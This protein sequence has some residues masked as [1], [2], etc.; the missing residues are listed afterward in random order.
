MHFDERTEG[1]YRIHAGALEAPGG[2]YIAAV[3]VSRVVGRTHS[4]REAYRDDCLSCGHR[5]A[6]AEA[7]LN[8]A[9]VRARAIIRNLPDRLSC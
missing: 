5:W 9:V 8:H 1:D 4:L 3:V 6:T 7:A 2:G